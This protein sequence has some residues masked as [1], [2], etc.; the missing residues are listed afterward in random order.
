M[1]WYVVQ[2]KPRQERIAEENLSRQNYAVYCP[3][4]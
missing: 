2:T 4:L 3:R 1:G